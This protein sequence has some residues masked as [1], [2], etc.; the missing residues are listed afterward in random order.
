MFIN[1]WLAA[2]KKYAKFEGRARRAEYWYFQ[3]VQFIILILFF[4]GFS[5]LGERAGV[6][7]MLYL[8]FAYGTLLPGLAVTVRRLHDI[9]RSG[10]MVLVQLIPIVGI[11]WIL[12]IL[13]K[14]GTKGANQYGAD[15]LEATTPVSV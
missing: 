2:M 9:N 7:Q 13:S 10:W 3:L 8:V 15:P 12:F 6:L 14:V 5:L 1:Y 11:F 4:V